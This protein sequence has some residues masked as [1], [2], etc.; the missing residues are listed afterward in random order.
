M[1]TALNASMTG[2][3]VLATL[4]TNDAASTIDRIKNMFPEE[5]QTSVL[6]ALSRSLYLIQSQR[7]YAN[8]KGELVLIVELL[9]NTQTI[10]TLIREKKIFQIPAVL[11]EQEEHLPWDNCLISLY[12]QGKLTMNEAL[13][14][15]KKGKGE[16]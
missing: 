11:A 7:L 13:A 2:H 12:N 1:K 5:E 8:E 9:K 4:H 15:A 14:L 6:D 10:A 16:G 3:V